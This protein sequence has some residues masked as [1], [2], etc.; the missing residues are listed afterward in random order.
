MTLQQ[1]RGIE[2]NERAAALAELVLWIGWLQWHIR[3]FGNASVAEPVIHDY[4]NIEHRDAV[5]AWDGQEPMRDASGALVTRWD[6]VTLQDASGHRR[7][8]A[9]RDARWCRSGRYLNPRPAEWPQADFIVGNP[10]FIGN[11]RMRDALGDGYVEALRGGVAGSAR[12]RRL[13]HVLVAARGRDSCDASSA[14]RFGLITTNS[15]DD[16][17]QPAGDRGA[18]GGKP[19]LHLAFAIPDHPWVD[20]ARWRRRAHRHDGGHARRRRRGAC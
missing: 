9:R 12:E 13:R 6:G 19:P 1:L 14:R 20:S 8:G 10:P 11:K 15:L 18:A 17:L 5:L 16:D 4:G 2:I 3:S 7:A